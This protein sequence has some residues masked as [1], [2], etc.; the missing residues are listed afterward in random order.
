MTR[1]Y[2]DSG[3]HRSV[4]AVLAPTIAAQFGVFSH[5]QA[6]VAGTSNDM[7]S[8]RIAAGRWE[9]LHR[10]VYRIAGSP[11][12]W[13]ASMMAGWLACGERAVVSGRAAAALWGLVAA[14]SA[15]PL[16]VSVPRGIRRAPAGV[17][18]HETTMLVAEDVAN[19][20]AFAVTTVART[21]IDLASV[22]P[23]ATVEESLD[24]AL[25]R[26]LVTVREVRARID[27]LSGLPGVAAMK[28]LLEMRA[29]DEPEPESRFE[30][31]LA[32]LLRQ[33][34]LRPKRQH[35]VRDEQ[36]RFVARIDFA[37]PDERLAVEADGH[38]Y[39]AG[40]ALWLRDLERCNTLTALGWRVHHVTWDRMTND[41]EG[42]ID[43]IGA[44]L[45][46]KA[47][48]RRSG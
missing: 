5:R 25:R 30:T 37:F 44:L 15:Q 8:R 31:R 45:S 22:L 33:D 7:V 4:E 3:S 1:A 6:V 40:R 24:E 11:P 17:L 18:V 19:V 35:V 14:P 9:R 10:G 43:E 29:D 48:R 38:R 36:G 39:H 2:R 21:L 46:A 16:E 12:S 32:R 26:R 27:G 34:G 47:R 28:A 23:Q 20:G 41:P 13:R 42:V